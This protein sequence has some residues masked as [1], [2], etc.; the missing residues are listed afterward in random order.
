MSDNG[1]RAAFWHQ[2][3]TQLDV[4][5]ISR[6]ISGVVGVLNVPDIP[7]KRELGGMHG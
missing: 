1:T 7:L 5:F 3:L 6:V 2:W 4:G